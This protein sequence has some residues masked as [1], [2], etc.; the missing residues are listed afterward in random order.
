MLRKKKKVRH[1]GLSNETTFG[2]CKF[3]MLSEQL[4]LP[5]PVS[6]QNDFSLLCRTF[7]RELAE[8][9]SPRH[10]N[11]GLMA[12]GV[13]A[14]GALTGKYLNAAKPQNSRHTLWPD[15]QSRYVGERSMNAVQKYVNLAESINIT[16]CQLA[17][18]WSRSR[19]Y[20]G[21]TI[22][23]ATKME[24]LKECIAAKDIELDME[25]L[26]KI[27]E[28]HLQGQNPNLMD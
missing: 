4:G 14:G 25:T 1:W 6:I 24:Q 10:F 5:P 8:A 3:S 26:K 13:L 21:S 28:I 12:Y 16:P 7:E 18:A 19:W 2:V 22:I 20:M 11:I 23:G 15:F 27:D 17:I 9:C